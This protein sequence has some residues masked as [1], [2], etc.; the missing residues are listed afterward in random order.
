MTF[1]TKLLRRALKR[2]RSRTFASYR[3]SVTSILECRSWVIFD[4]CIRYPR[5]SMSVVTPVDGVI[6][7]PACGW[8]KILGAAFQADGGTR[9]ACTTSSIRRRSAASCNLNAV[10]VDSQCSWATDGTR[11]SVDAPGRGLP[12]PE[13]GCTAVGSA[14]GAQYALRL[15]WAIAV[16]DRDPGAVAPTYPRACSSRG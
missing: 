4:R 15:P 8:L 16:T 14:G 11:S 10:T 5:R 13:P 2:R 9:P 12:I 3:K 1:F 7:R 6:G